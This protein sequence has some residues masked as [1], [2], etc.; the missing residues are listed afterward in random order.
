MNL[1]MLGPPGA[2]KG[3]QAARLSQT[4]RIPTIA[5][6]DILR[7]Q[8]AAGTPLGQRSRPVLDRGELIPDEFV[9][10]IIRDRLLDPDTRRGFVLDGSPRTVPQA[11]A[12]DAL[13]GELDRPIDFVLYLDV[14]DPKTLVERLSLRAEL[15]GRS[16][17]RPDVIGR[18]IDV[19]LAQTAPL[20]DYYR[21]QGKLRSI[22]GDQPPDRVF[23]SIEVALASGPEQTQ[24][25]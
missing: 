25:S 22:D 14:G 6:G 24:A 21:E 20:I 9:I 3:T 18:R 5:T 12:L 13:L 23:R 8:A 7:A 17:D 1:V 2:G 19:F 10:D 15:D 16:D 11:R 4:Y